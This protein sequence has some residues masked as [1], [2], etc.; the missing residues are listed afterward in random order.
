MSDDELALKLA[1]ALEKL[2]VASCGAHGSQ[3][4]LIED[5]VELV[6]DVF[7]TLSLYGETL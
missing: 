7:D 6:R 1:E 5:A 4:Q 3:A 2:E